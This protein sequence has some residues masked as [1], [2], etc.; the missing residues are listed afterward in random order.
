MFTEK[1]LTSFIE[2]PENVLKECHD[3]PVEIAGDDRSYVVM[4]SE[5]LQRLLKDISLADQLDTILVGL[6][7]KGGVPEDRV[8]GLLEIQ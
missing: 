1:P 6:K 8:M 2:H 5:F 4:T 7:E 3:G